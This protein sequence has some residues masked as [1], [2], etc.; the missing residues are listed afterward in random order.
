MAE[1]SKGGYIVPHNPN[2][3]NNRSQRRNG[4]FSYQPKQEAP[5][6]PSTVKTKFKSK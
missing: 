2:Q 3:G 1:K 4:T 5:K 6:P